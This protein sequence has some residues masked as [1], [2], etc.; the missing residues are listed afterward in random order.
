MKLIYFYSYYLLSGEIVYFF[1]KL[2]RKWKKKI[3]MG[4]Y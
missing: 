3:A 4:I 2:P 1:E